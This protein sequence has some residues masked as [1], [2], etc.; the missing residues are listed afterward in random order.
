MAGAGAN[1]AGGDLQAAFTQYASFGASSPQTEIDNAKFNKLFKETKIIDKSGEA[2]ALFFIC[3]SVLIMFFLRNLFRYLALYFLSP[4][5]NGIV[6]D[7]RNVTEG[8][9]SP[10]GKGC[11][12]LKRGIEI[13]HIFQLGNLY[14]KKMGRI[15]YFFMDMG[16]TVLVYRLVIEALLL[17][18]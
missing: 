17:V 8:D 13:G 3:M 9:P 1:K 15:L 16:H 7:I 2:E 12:T 4:I 14:S 6:K 18:L 10:C 11:L 5:R